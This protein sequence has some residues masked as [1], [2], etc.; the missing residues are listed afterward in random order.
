MKKSQRRHTGSDLTAD[1]ELADK[2][3]AWYRKI[4]IDPESPHRFDPAS[5]DN[6]RVLI[7]LVK[8]SAWCVRGTG[9]YVQAII[10]G[11]ILYFLD[12]R[13]SNGRRRAHRPRRD[14]G[15]PHHW[16]ATT[17][18][19]LATMTGLSQNQVEH[20]L[21]RL[22]QKQYICS[23]SRIFRGNGKL[24]GCK[25]SFIWLGPKARETLAAIKRSGQ[26]LAVPVYLWAMRA[27]GGDKFAA[28]VLSHVW[29]RLHEKYPK[30]YSISG[31]PQ[32]EDPNLP[33]ISLSR[34][35]IARW[36]F[37]SVHTVKRA[38]RVLRKLGLIK[39]NQKRF[40]TVAINSVSIN[41]ERCA[42]YILMGGI[43]PYLAKHP[44]FDD[45]EFEE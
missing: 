26:P 30:R 10:L 25:C 42:G 1:N 17:A 15:L 13:K 35:A 14:R 18:S 5:L 19:L 45:S 24:A 7:R 39:S 33:G 41:Y 43:R 37:T 36:T 20:A 29:Y 32:P 8:V 44:P 16:M 3:L 27:C 2:W 38:L 28:V 31:S 21:K 11:Q 34:S 40:G 9:S 12:G 22:K 6:P 4:V 23:D